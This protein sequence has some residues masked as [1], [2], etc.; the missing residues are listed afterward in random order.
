MRTIIT[1]ALALGLAACAGPDLRDETPGTAAAPLPTGI[2]TQTY[3]P[4]ATADSPGTATQ[5]PTAQPPVT[6]PMPPAQPQQPT[7]PAR[8][9]GSSTPPDQL[10]PPPGSGMPQA[11]P[12]PMP[13]TDATINQFKRNQMQTDVDRLRN[14][15]ALGRL[16]PLQQR[17]LMNRQHEMDRLGR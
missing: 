17:D 3:I 9:R 14:Q 7:P 6:R 16:D 11:V 8:R 4:A 2:R 15:D 12:A 13:N 1:A 5:P 10:F